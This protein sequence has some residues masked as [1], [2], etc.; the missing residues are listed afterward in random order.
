MKEPGKITAF[1][2]PV[3]AGVRAICLLVS[4]Y[5]LAYDLQ[6]LVAF[7]HLIVHTGDVKGPASLHPAVP[8]RTA[9]LLVRRNLIERGLLLMMSRGLVNRV[10]DTSGILYRA[11]EYADTFLSSLTASYLEALRQRG[12]WVLNTFGELDDEGLRHMM[13][14]FFGQWI[15]EFETLQRRME[16]ET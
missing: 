8:L 11:S 10:I 6:R 7:D 1:N 2:S 3:E 4:A 5:P 13:T 9:E 12:E 15:E 14:R 16:I